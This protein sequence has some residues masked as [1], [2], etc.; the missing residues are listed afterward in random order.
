M[1]IE[2]IFDCLATRPFADD[3]SLLNDFVN[4]II[5]DV[6]WDLFRDQEEIC[7]MA[8]RTAPPLLK[9]NVVDHIKMYV[10]RELSFLRIYITTY[11]LMSYRFSNIDLGPEAE[12]W[13][14]EELGEE[15]YEAFEKAAKEYIYNDYVKHLGQEKADA[16][17]ERIGRLN[18]YKK[19]VIE[20]GDESHLLSSTQE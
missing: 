2:E 1:K 10:N 4:R 3:E 18:D 5:F 12:W 14:K 13:L 15:E 20:N 6:S 9:D 16:Y 19:E 17:F 11:I 7:N 8:T